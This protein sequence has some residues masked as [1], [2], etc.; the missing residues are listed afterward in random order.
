MSRA[1]SRNV[2]RFIS[3]LEHK[4]PKDLRVI[5]LQYDVDKGRA[6]RI[7]ATARGKLAEAVLKIAEEHRIPLYED[8]SLTDLLAKLKIDTEIPPELYTLVAEVLAFVYQ[9]DKMAK[10]RRSVE[11][12]G[13]KSL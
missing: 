9:L 2:K 6:P 5:A 7:V 11:K 13:K 12:G 1:N 4:D 8:P 3:D 10:K